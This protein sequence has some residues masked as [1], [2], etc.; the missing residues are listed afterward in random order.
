M[1]Q[2]IIQV[3]RSWALVLIVAVA[4]IS[5]G[6]NDP[7]LEGTYEGSL[8]ME[9]ETVLITLKLIDG[10][11]ASLTGLYDESVEGT[12]KE[13]SVGDGLDKDG[14]FAS[15]E[16]SDYEIKLKLLT[17]KN[18]FQLMDFTGRKKNAGMTIHRSFKLKRAN[19][20]LRRISR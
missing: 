10:G 4:G 11:K 14:I 3:F 1:N 8:A 12:W 6:G 7:A 18:G 5:C 2:S 17:I 9:D 15:F 19:P 16:F 20:K 13:E